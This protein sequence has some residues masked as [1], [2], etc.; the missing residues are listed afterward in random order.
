MFEVRGSPYQTCLWPWAPVG[1]SGWVIKI[2]HC[3]KS[4]KRASISPQ[5]CHLHCLLFQGYDGSEMMSLE[6]EISHLHKENSHVMMKIIIKLIMIM[7][8]VIIITIININFLTI[9][10]IVRLILSSIE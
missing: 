10:T 2:S 6:E 3:Q 9:M 5:S 8:L 1:Q 4:F 7:T